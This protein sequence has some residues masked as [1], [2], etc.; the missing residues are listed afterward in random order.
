MKKG[1]VNADWHP[2]SLGHASAGEEAEL[3]EEL[4]EPADLGASLVIGALLVIPVLIIISVTVYLRLR[5]KGLLS[6]HQRRGP[7]TTALTRTLDT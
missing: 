6:V 4:E 3:E 1:G 7:Y 5:S 2:A